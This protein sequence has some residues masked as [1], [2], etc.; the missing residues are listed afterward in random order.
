VSYHSITVSL[1]F[2]MFWSKDC[3]FQFV[4]AIEFL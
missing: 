2:S 4:S 1:A 3:I